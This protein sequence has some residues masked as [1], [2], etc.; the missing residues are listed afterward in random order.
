MKTSVKLLSFKDVS[1]NFSPEEREYLSPAQCTLYRDVMLENYRN[2]VSLAIP[3]H[4]SGGVG[5]ALES[6][7]TRGRSSISS[8][9]FSVHRA[10]QK[11][12]IPES[13]KRKTWK[14]R[15]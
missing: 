9:V 1:I 11:A 2:L 13:N 8:C 6:E 4:I 7:E 10:K 14:A 15:T 5:R 12:F 3:Y